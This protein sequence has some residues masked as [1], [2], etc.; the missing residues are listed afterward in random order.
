MDAAAGV[1]RGIRC[2]HVVVARWLRQRQRAAAAPPRLVGEVPG[3]GEGPGVEGPGVGEGPDVEGPGVEA[4]VGGRG[5]GGGV[6]RCLGVVHEGRV[7]VGGGIGAAVGAGVDSGGGG[8]LD[9]LVEGVRER[10]GLVDGVGR[11]GLKADLSAK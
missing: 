4:G 6:L 11:V 2:C 1:V 8:W 7:A 10:C 3:V 5:A 9:N